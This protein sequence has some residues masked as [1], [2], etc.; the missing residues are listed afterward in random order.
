MRYIYNLKTKEKIFSFSIIKEIKDIDQIV[1]SKY[2]I[3]E[4]NN[5]NNIN[6]LNNLSKKLGTIFL[7]TGTSEIEI[8][9]NRIKLIKEYGSNVVLI[10]TQDDDSLFNLSCIDSYQQLDIEYG[11]SCK[12]SN[13][14][15]ASIIK[16]IAY[17]DYLFDD[18]LLSQFINIYQSN[19][20]QNK[21][22]IERTEINYFENSNVLKVNKHIKSGNIIKSK[23]LD[24][25]SSNDNNSIKSIFI[26]QV[27]NL[28]TIKDIE[29]DFLLQSNCFYE[30]K[31]YIVGDS[32]L[33]RGYEKYDYPFPWIAYSNKFPNFNNIYDTCQS[34]N[35]GYLKHLILQNNYQNVVIQLGI[36][37]CAPRKVIYKM[38]NE[39]SV[40]GFEFERC[41]PE[42]EFLDF[43][44]FKSENIE[45]Y[46]KFSSENSKFIQEK[47]Y[48][49]YKNHNQCIKKE[50]FEKNI[51]TFYNN[52]FDKFNKIYFISILKCHREP[53]ER[54]FMSDD[55]IN[56]Y[57]NILI[58][59]EKELEKFVYIDLYKNVSDLEKYI[60]KIMSYNRNDNW[61]QNKDFKEDGYHINNQYYYLISKKLDENFI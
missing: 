46:V 7:Y 15:V 10:H 44:K 23:D 53:N 14:V 24:L 22:I 20:L 57:N 49:F 59:L 11:I 17:I 12:N 56:I 3:V 50:I 37:D 31:N 29:K 27:T 5:I 35:T 55:I 48:Q 60:N 28:K 4:S 52:N 38:I 16:G 58:R 36:N 40:I 1:N 21:K 30:S 19:L 51:R 47:Y 9:K 18:N 39:K 8:I 43:I 41:L 61:L 54:N 45:E 26:D 34:R 42:K 33:N 2:F 32:L 6:L 25:V 13:Y